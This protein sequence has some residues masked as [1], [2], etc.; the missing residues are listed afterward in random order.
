MSLESEKLKLEIK[1]VGVLLGLLGISIYLMIFFWDSANYFIYPN[2]VV[3]LLLLL[4]GACFA[5]FYKLD[6]ID[7]TYKRKIRNATIQ[8]GDF[9]DR[10]IITPAEWRSF[11]EILENTVRPFWLYIFLGVLAGAIFSVF[12]PV[13]FVI[14]TEGTV[15]VVRLLVLSAL[16]TGASYILGKPM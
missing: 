8:E 5:V 9:Q 1:Y 10:W 3:V 14:P 15:F 7:V 12:T 4:M 6:V 16:M 11:Q 13:E 2:Y